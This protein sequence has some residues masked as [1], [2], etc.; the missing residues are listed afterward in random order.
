MYNQTSRKHFENIMPP[1]ITLMEITESNTGMTMKEKWSLAQEL[2]DIKPIVSRDLL[3]VILSYK[4]HRLLNMSDG[5]LVHD[6]S[7]V[8]LDC[9]SRSGLYPLRSQWANMNEDSTRKLPNSPSAFASVELQ[10]LSAASGARI[11]RINGMPG[12]ADY[13]L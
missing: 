13:S 5:T 1:N 3:L 2:T 10:G 11:I 4:D 6:I 7:I 9:W 8:A 12:V